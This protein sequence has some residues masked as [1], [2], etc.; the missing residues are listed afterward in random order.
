MKVKESHT[1]MIRN[2]TKRLYGVE[3]LFQVPVRYLCIYIDTIEA[4]ITDIKTLINDFTNRTVFN[5]FKVFRLNIKRIKNPI[6][7]DMELAR[8]SPVTCNFV[9]LR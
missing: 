2:I 8:A 4:G 7:N 5:F 1:K 9:S 3:A 6:V